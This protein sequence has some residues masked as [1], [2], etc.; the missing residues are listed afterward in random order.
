[1]CFHV[2]RAKDDAHPALADALDQ[3]EAANHLTDAQ[4]GVHIGSI[5]AGGVDLQEPHRFIVR[6]QQ[7]FHFGS[8]LGPAGTP[9][10][11][12]GVA[13]VWRQLHRIREQRLDVVPGVHIRRSR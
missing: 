7:R 8:Q 3:A 12:H 1:M 11:Q 9:R 6:G 2:L 10:R 13:L 4:Y 5:L